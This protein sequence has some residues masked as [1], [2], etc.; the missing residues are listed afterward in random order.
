MLFDFKI[1]FE[2]YRGET[3][4]NFIMNQNRELY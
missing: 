4:E 2:K 1:N 3:V